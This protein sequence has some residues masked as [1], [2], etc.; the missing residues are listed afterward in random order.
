[1]QLGRLLAQTMV[2]TGV[3]ADADLVTPIPV[4]WW[5]RL[6]RGFNASSVIAEGMSQLL[7][8]SNQPTLRSIRLTKKQ[9]TLSTS[10]RIANVKGAMK[11]VNR[12]RVSGKRVVLVDDVATSCATANEA[13][14]ALFKAGAKTVTLAVAARGVRR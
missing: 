10:A 11:I 6:V 4:H 9:G 5:K 1:M 3:G 13:T 14:I 12:Q 8:L 2:E 7:Q